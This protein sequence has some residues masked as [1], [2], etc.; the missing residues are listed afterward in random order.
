MPIF[1]SPSQ[2]GASTLENTI[3]LLV[4]LLLLIAL[5][6]SAHWLLL[7]QALNTA[8]LDTARIAATQQAH[9]QIIHDAFTLQLQRLPAFFA[10]TDSSHWQI[11][12]R[13]TVSTNYDQQKSSPMA[14]DVHF[15]YQALQYTQGN[16]EVFNANTL[17][18]RLH[19]LHKPI[20]PVIRYFL[21]TVLSIA[22]SP[23]QS[24]YA[25]GH[26]PIVTDIQVAMQSDH[27]SAAYLA[28]PKTTATTQNTQIPPWVNQPKDLTDL[29]LTTT[30]NIW[31]P[32][33]YTTPNF[34]TECKTGLCCLIH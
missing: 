13:R 31:Q 5:Y 29:P 10:N 9:P 27:S 16:T 14:A 24:V 28:S 11:E 1:I 2:R 4:L 17:H 23:Y 30:P 26:L 19:Y 15:D 25:Q 8:L 22:S 12:K 20:T 32:P 6:E 7:R 18:L 3:V 33:T 21:R 34:D